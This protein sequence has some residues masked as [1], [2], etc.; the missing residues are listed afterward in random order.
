ML[1]TNR[2]PPTGGK[3][4]PTRTIHFVLPTLSFRATDFFAAPTDFSLSPYGV[5]VETP[6]SPPATI[7][8]QTPNQKQ[9]HFRLVNPRIFLLMIFSFRVYQLT[10][11]PINQQTKNGWRAG[12]PQSPLHSPRFPPAAAPPESL[13]RQS[14]T[15]RLTNL[16]TCRTSHLCFSTSTHQAFIR[17]SIARPLQPGIYLIGRT[18][19]PLARHFPSFAHA[20]RASVGRRPLIAT[21]LRLHPC[22]YPIG[23]TLVT[24]CR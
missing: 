2:L 13:S 1:P 12:P 5:T 10:N 18:L 6:A 16:L 24:P 21:G 11:Q 7:P 4:R 3:R 8:T 23:R 17:I 9:T 20:I 14:P 19:V 22:I 15:T